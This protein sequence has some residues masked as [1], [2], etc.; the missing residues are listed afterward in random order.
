MLPAFTDLQEGFELGPWTVIPDRGLLRQGTVEV[1]LEPMVMDVLMVLAG[2]QGNVV[3]RDQLV[4]AVWDG[5]FVG[6]DVIVAKIATLRQ[7]LGDHARD[8]KYIETV[9]RRGYRLM[10]PVKLPEAPEAEVRASRFPQ[11]SD[12]HLIAGLAIVAIAIY[13]WGPRSIDSVSVLEF[14]C[15][16]NQLPKVEHI[17]A[18]FN[19]ELPIS[20]QDPKLEVTRGPDQKVDADVVGKLSFTGNRIHVK[21]AIIL[22]NGTTKW[23]SNFDGSTNAVFDLQAR[24][25]TALR[26]VLLGGSGSRVEAA[27]RP[28]NPDADAQYALGLFFLAKRDFASLIRAQGHFEKTIDYDARFGPAYLR[29]AIT[30]LLLSDYSTDS[31]QDNFAQAIEVVNRGVQAD[32]SI[33]E[34]AEVVHGFVYHQYG[35]WAAATAA[36]ETALRG[37]TVYPTAYQWDSR[38]R[39]ALGFLNQSL[40]QARTALAMEPASQVLN[41]RVANAYLW[42]NDMPN[43][44]RYFERANSMGI[45]APIHYFGNTMFL[46]R[47]GRINE[48]RDSV[49]HALQLFS[50]DYSWVDPV[51]EYLLQRNSQDLQVRAY[52]TAEQMTADDDIAPYIGMIVWA[53]FGEADRV[54]NIAMQ[55]A[56]SGKLHEHES[57]QI[58]IIYLDELKLLRDHKDFPKLLKNLGLTDYWDSVRCQWANDMV[59][60]P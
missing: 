54:M 50:A 3:T 27:K 1:R 43:A 13:I 31:R 30:H 14:E 11:V 25:A 58:E 8:P 40:D 20:L 4:D 18:A 29:L 59:A 45:G 39:S 5:R 56:E 10:I 51:F 12:R 46:L 28:A 16:S 47:D 34:A 52:Q 37:K 22:A 57:A 2:H 17:C 60:C 24:V 48:A 53:L 15:L 35:N 32:P 23:A 49:K 21:V 19:T 42:I 41:S 33:R 6:D 44:R 36:F 7:K 9:P 26:G 38:L 55:V